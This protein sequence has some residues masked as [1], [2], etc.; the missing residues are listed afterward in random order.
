MINAQLQYEIEQFLYREAQMLSERRYEEWLELFTEDCRYWMP[1]RET[2]SGQPDALAT[3]NEM[4][5]F[6][7]D[8]AFLRAR[9]E[10]LRSALA[11]AE[12]PASRMRYFIT[13]VQIDDRNVDEIEVQCNLQVF[14]SRTERTEVNYVGRREDRLCR[15]DGAWQIKLRKIILDQTLIPRTLSIFL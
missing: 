15:I 14:Q 2:I 7:D 9:V 12:Q 13:N 3:D 1:A 11:H 5:Y 6:D 10:R 8:K 4:A